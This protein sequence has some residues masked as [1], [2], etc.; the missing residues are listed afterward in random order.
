VKR[1]AGVLVGVVAWLAATTGARAHELDEY[2]Q[3]TLVSIERDRVQFEIN[4]TPGVAIASQV[5][6]AID[7]NRDAAISLAEGESYARR[8]LYGVWLEVDERR[9]PVEL[10]SQTFPTLDEM[11]QGLGT[12]RLKAASIV[13]SS[14]GSHTV[15]IRNTHQPAISVYQA[16]ALVPGD[17]AISIQAQRRDPQQRELRI[18]YQVKGSGRGRAVSGVIAFF[19]IWI[20]ARARRRRESSS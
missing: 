5:A 4:L 10:V 8:V 17:K 3:A 15:L 1:A 6:A 7:T 13:S 19:V 9:K 12:I 20:A 11:A 2:L 18:D 14:S 16:N